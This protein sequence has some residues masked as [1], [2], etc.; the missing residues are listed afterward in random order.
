MAR[1]LRI[2]FPGAYYHVTARGVNRA[3]IYFD[4]ED[5][6]LFLEKLAT[7]HIRFDLIIHGHC[8]MSNHYHL[9]VDK[10]KPDVP[11][12]NKARLRPNLE[13]VCRVVSD[14]YGVEPTDLHVRGGHGNEARKVCLYVAR[15]RTG[16]RMAEIGALLGNI[17][18]AAVSKA[19]SQLENQIKTHRKLRARVQKI[20]NELG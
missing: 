4:D 2:E 11:A 20:L 16:L 5:H 6:E 13:Q 19:A 7:A 9:E 17:C 8:E 12:L 3:A 15:Q 18:P 10:A 1:P 14:V